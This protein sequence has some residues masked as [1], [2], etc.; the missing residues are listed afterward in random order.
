VIRVLRVLADLILK[1]IE[2]IWHIL[3]ELG[4]MLRPVEGL[5]VDEQMSS[6]RVTCDALRFP[7]VGFDVNHN[8]L[9]AEY[10][11]KCL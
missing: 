7:V 5:V 1:R 4:G 9:A 8:P 3:T 11:P 6:C 2:L 10:H